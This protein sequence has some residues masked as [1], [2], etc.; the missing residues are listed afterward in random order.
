VQKGGVN[1]Q[2]GFINS[3]VSLYNK[4]RK[5]RRTHMQG[6]K[7]KKRDGEKELSSG[8]LQKAVYPGGGRIRPQQ[9][10]GA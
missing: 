3:G 8:G 4:I 10:R 6:G 5:R 7:K 2:H 1:A 9:R